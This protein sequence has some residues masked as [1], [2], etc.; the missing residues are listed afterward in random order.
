LRFDPKLLH[1]AVDDAKAPRERFFERGF[2][3]VE[4][5]LIGTGESG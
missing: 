4:Q 3:R 2:G 5:P 1:V